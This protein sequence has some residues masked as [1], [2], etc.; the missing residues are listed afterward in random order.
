MWVLTSQYSVPYNIASLIATLYNLPLR[1]DGTFLSRGKSY[2]SILFI[3]TAPSRCMTSS[4]VSPLRLLIQ[5]TW[6]FL[7]WGWILCRSSLPH[8]PHV[9]CHWTC[10]PSLVI[11]IC[12]KNDNRFK[13]TRKQLQLIL[14]E[15]KDLPICPHIPQKI[16]CSFRKVRWK[17]YRC[18]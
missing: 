2:A 3:Y 14:T 4:S 8:P 11:I 16:C 13:V 18:M 5:H 9:L 12:L 17:A 7:S 6:S 10:I 15:Q 1:L